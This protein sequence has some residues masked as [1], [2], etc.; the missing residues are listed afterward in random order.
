M[1]IFFVPL[2]PI[3]IAVFLIGSSVASELQQRLDSILVI[4]T[5]IIIIAYVIIAI[6]NLVNKYL[7]TTRKV[8]STIFCVVGAIVSRAA[9]KMFLSELASIKSDVF[10]LIEFAF[11]G[12]VGGAICLLVVIGCMYFCYC[13]IGQND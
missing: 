10:L 11:V 6:S 3:L 12:L 13:V 9:V 5:V 4:L 7:S 2:V 8:L 1:V